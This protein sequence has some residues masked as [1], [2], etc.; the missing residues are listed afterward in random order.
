MNK[1]NF[2]TMSQADLRAY[3]LSHPED[4]EG[5]HALV[6][7]FRADPRPKYH[8]IEDLEK[9]PEVQRARQKAEG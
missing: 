7:R 8:S 5:F 1:S 6:D 9:L 3:V 4:Q 2:D